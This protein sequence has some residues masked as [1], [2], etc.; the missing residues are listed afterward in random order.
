MKLEDFVR[1]PEETTLLALRLLDGRCRCNAL[2]ITKRHYVDPVL[3]KRWLDEHLRRLDTLEDLHSLH[4]ITLAKAKLQNMYR[5][6]FEALEPDEQKSPM[7]DMGSS[8]AVISDTPEDAPRE[9]APFS[10]RLH[11]RD[12]G[13]LN[14]VFSKIDVVEAPRNIGPAVQAFL[15]LDKIPF[16]A[17][18]D[19]SHLTTPNDMLI[20]SLI[21]GHNP[22]DGILAVD[23][24][25]GQTQLFTP[26]ISKGR[27][28]EEYTRGGRYSEL[29]KEKVDAGGERCDSVRLY[30]I[31]W[32]GMQEQA[33]RKYGNVDDIEDGAL[34]TTDRHYNR[35]F[36]TLP[37]GLIV[38]GEYHYINGVTHSP[39][40]LVGPD[41]IPEHEITSQMLVLWWHKLLR[42]M[43]GRRLQ[44]WM[45]I[46]DVH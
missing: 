23:G 29:L 10:S 39:S 21:R 41:Y 13:S 46:F 45:T 32:P 27:C 40:G 35:L 15:G 14:E 33:E 37:R 26:V 17:I 25:K 12:R 44:G 19:R 43:E 31:D 36:P 16:L 42:I 1:R 20:A 28:F 8:V 30:E 24:D 38:D 5:K 2:G 34:M 4:E 6:M 18:V 22:A 7:P 3:A 9:M 11:L